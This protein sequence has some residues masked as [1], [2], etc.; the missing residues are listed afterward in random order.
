[1]TEEREERR[2]EGR[3]ATGIGRLGARDLFL[4]DTKMDM[5]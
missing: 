2:E 4:F 1:M 5:R 3:K